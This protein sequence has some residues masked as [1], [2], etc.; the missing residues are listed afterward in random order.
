[1]KATLVKVGDAL[2]LRR[3][4]I[5]V[6]GTVRHLRHYP[7]LRRPRRPL[8]LHLGCGK[9]RLPGFINVDLNISSAT[10]Y[11]SDISKLP[12]PSG[13]VE[14]IETYHVIEHIPVTAVEAVLTEWRR[15][16]QP[17]GV[18]VIECPDFA[19]VVDELLAGNSE[20]MFSIFGR[21][22]FRGDAHHWGYT[23]DTLAD[24]L[25]RVGF[26]AVATGTPSDYHTESEPCIRV[27]ATA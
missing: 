10:D 22:R 19:A 13:S 17:G 7:V 27:E 2:G 25:R 26:G 8:R 21:Q 18:L 23:E 11:V 24:L 14:R 15:V 3:P 20:R 6:L 9:R 4:F 1:M 16:L 5:W 12:C